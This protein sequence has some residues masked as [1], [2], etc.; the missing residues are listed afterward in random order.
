MLNRFTHVRNDEVSFGWERCEHDGSALSELVADLAESIIEL[1]CGGVPG[2]VGSWQSRR[3]GGGHTVPFAE[4]QLGEFVGLGFGLP[5]KPMTADHLE[6]SVAESLWYLLA[7]EFT[8]DDP[9]VFASP[10][11]L[12][13]TDHGAD[14]YLIHRGPGGLRF[15][16]WEIKKYTGGGTVRATV[17]RASRQL[18][19]N[20][21]GY[22]ARQIPAGQY[23]ND[24][25]V[26]DLIVRGPEHWLNGATEAGV[27]VAVTS[28]SEACADERFEKLDSYFG[29]LTDPD[30]IRG[31]ATGVLDFVDLARRVQQELWSG[32]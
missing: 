18:D 3:V 7:S 13:P 15:R 26:R 28:A 1:R 23:H 20:A 12:A 4:E 32:L 10:P 25:D 19:K 14:G 30:Q 6:G 2:L 11:D 22:L 16:L 29:G 24:A 21:L 31:M 17:Q 5:T 8:H 27:G 9:V